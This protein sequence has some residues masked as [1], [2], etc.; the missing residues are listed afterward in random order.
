MINNNKS[1]EFVNAD[2]VQGLETVFD[3][4]VDVFGEWSTIATKVI[5]SEDSVLIY[6]DDCE[7]VYG[8]L[9]EPEE[10]VIE[11]FDSDEAYWEAFEKY[12]DECAEFESEINEIYEAIITNFKSGFDLDV[13]F[14]SFDTPFI[15][16]IPIKR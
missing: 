4:L 6:D 9:D 3:A 8:G 11:D 10:P 1:V 5:I 15:L 16:S 13:K 2:H 7:F 12:E 14:V